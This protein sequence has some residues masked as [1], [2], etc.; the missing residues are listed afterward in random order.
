M[1]VH[2]C[3]CWDVR[4]RMPIPNEIAED[5]IGSPTPGDVRV[6]VGPCTVSAFK[7]GTGGTKKSCTTR[8]GRRKTP[9]FH[10][11]GYPIGRWTITNTGRTQYDLTARPNFAG[12]EA[13][14]PL[15]P[16]GEPRPFVTHA[17]CESS[18]IKSVL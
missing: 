2:A 10:S 14:C 16:G 5:M 3:E 15:P 11:P 1:R 12:Y 7:G 13:T 8:S 6:Y 18:E 4:R 17:Y 9:H